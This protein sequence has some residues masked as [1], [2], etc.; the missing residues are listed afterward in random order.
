MAA[1]QAP[2]GQKTLSDHVKVLN[3]VK[4]IDVLSTYVSNPNKAYIPLTCLMSPKETKTYFESVNKP[5][6]SMMTS[7]PIRKDKL[8]QNMLMLTQ[9]SEFTSPLYQL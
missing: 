1:D 5:E 3:P 8:P 9:K 4:S 2:V 6:K 7:R